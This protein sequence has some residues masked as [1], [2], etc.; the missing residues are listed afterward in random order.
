[1]ALHGLTT[2]DLGRVNCVVRTV[3]RQTTPPQRRGRAIPP[4]IS[5]KM[6]IAEVDNHTDCSGGYY[7]CHLQ[8][9]DATNWNTSESD[10]LNNSSDDTVEV[11]NLAEIGSSIN[12][13]NSGDLII[14]WKHTD[15]ED[16]I[17][18]IGNEVFGRHTFGEW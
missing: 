14:C 8:S 13:L 11:L 17:R 9:L 16:N 15:D 4:M 5:G 18:Y 2:K 3:E 1:M 12:N 10:Q 7:N 6:Y